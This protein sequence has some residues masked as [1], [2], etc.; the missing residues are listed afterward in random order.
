MLYETEEQQVEAL[1]KWWKENGTSV[2]AGVAIGLIGVFGWRAW[3][4]HRDTVAAQASNLF[5]QLV[6]SVEA[7]KADVAAQQATLL[8]SEYGSTPYAAFAEL[9]EART[10]YEKGDLL[11]AK[12][13][14][15]QAIVKA[16]DPAFEQMAVLRLARIQIGAGELDAARSLLD[17]HPA[18][19]PF[20]AEYATLR[21]DIAR[22][23]GDLAAARRAYQKAIAGKAGNAD[24]IQLKLDNLPPS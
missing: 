23:R 13:A 3:V 1:K 14:L 22:A 21:G 5:D 11:G 6:I 7:G 9:M 18:S 12:D 4:S 24:L 15:G 10:R 16:P 17:E 2:I 20:A 8:R 19:P